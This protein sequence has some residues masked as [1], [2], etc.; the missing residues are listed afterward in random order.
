MK[1]KLCL[2]AALVLSLFSVGCV[3][4]IEARMEIKQA[5]EAYNKEDYATALTHYSKARRVDPNSFPDLDRM[6]GYSQIGLYIPDIKTPANEA[7]ADHA[8]I[9]L[10]NYL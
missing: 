5:N 7:H 2:F 1:K 4:K 10:R 3:N 6:I 9:E 8:I